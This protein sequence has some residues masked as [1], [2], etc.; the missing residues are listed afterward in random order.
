M[1]GISSMRATCLPTL[2]LFYGAV[3]S[4]SSGSLVDYS[5]PRW[6]C[7]KRSGR[8]VFLNSFSEGESVNDVYLRYGG[9]S[10]ATWSSTLGRIAV[11]QL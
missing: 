8:P 2:K 10:G 3:E 7:L 11:W 5:S 4:E 1:S 6:H 9:S